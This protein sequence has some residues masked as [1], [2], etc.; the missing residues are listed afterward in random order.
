MP[1]RSRWRA[2]TWIIAGSTAAVVAGVVVAGVLVARGT[3]P[4]Q[5][6]DA[7]SGE[8]VAFSGTDPITGRRVSAADYAGK[9]VVIN[10]W[11]TW[12]PGCVAEADDL[13]TFSQR[14]AE[15]QVIGVD[16]QDSKSA[17]R[18]FYERWGWRHPSVNDPDGKIAF[19]LGL[20]GMPTTFFLDRD[21]RI[22]ARIVGATDLA[23][24]EQGL[25]EALAGT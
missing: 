14:H 6:V 21:H 2:R 20:Q 19:S 11:A 13:R 15:V 9:P 7:S 5:A 1:A 8:T 25:Q 18:D 17:A 10:V 23:G 12:C 24:F 4:A 3:G 16:L 22:V